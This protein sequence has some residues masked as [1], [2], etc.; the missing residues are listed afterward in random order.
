MS[1]ATFCLILIFHDL[2][3]IFSLNSKFHDLFKKSKKN[4]WF[5]QFIQTPFL[6]ANNFFFFKP[7]GF[8]VT[9]ANNHK[10]SVLRWS[11]KWNKKIGSNC[12]E[13]FSQLSMYVFLVS[14]YNVINKTKLTFSIFFLSVSP[15]SQSTTINYSMSKTHQ[16]TISLQM[17]CVV[18]HTI[19]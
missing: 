14:L 6:P 19:I 7:N 5:F 12:I 10:H 11:K 9:K 3:M 17:S 13:H 2:S 15:C 8:Q 1:S 4:P 18:A 16:S